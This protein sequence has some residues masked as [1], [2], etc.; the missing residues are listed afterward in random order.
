LVDVTGNQRRL[1]AILAADVVGYTHLMEQNTDGTVADWKA[2]RSNIIE[3]TIASHSGRLVKLTG[4]GFL[5][6]FSVVQ[7]AVNCAVVIQEMLTESPLNF[8]M[9]INLG[10]IVDDGQDILGSPSHTC[11]MDSLRAPSSTLR[12]H[13]A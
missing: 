11:P 2:A 5:V 1:S 8:R 13:C 10:D 6:E 12:W 7:N 4:D 9:G 3:P